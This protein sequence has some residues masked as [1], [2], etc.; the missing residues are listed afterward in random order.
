[1][2]SNNTPFG[3]WRVA[4]PEGM[5]PYCKSGEIVDILF[6]IAFKGEHAPGAAAY[7]GEPTARLTDP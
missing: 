2:G 1:M 3:R 5:A 4:Q 7:A 6:S